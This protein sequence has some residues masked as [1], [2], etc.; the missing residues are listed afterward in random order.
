MAEGSGHG[1]SAVLEGVN[2]LCLRGAVRFPLRGCGQGW[3][4][5]CEVEAGPPLHLRPQCCKSGRPVVPC[6]FL[7]RKKDACLGHLVLRLGLA[8]CQREQVDRQAVP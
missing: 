7:S 3:P 8:F 1:K 5:G 4:V 6:L 2:L